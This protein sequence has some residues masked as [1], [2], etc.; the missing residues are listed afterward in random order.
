[1]WL[2]R[3]QRFQVGFIWTKS[4]LLIELKSKSYFIMENIADLWEK[5]A[6]NEEN[7]RSTSFEEYVDL[8]RAVKLALIAV[9]QHR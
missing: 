7:Q 9:S 5:I 3:F 1:M 4:H 6:K 8:K 2:A